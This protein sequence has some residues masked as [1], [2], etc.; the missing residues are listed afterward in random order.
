MQPLR[1]SFAGWQLV[2]VVDYRETKVRDSGFQSLAEK[3]ATLNLNVV[4]ESRPLVLGDVMWLARR[5]GPLGT[6]EIVLNCIVEVVFL[7]CS[8]CLLS[9]IFCCVFLLILML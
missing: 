6:E 9:F 4:V 2:L 7:S 8:L 1:Q 5:D 3:A